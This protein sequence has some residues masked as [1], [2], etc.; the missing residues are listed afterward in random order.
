MNKMQSSGIIFLNVANNINKILS[1]YR[2][3]ICG[4]VQY[5]TKFGHASK[6]AFPWCVRNLMRGTT[7][8][9]FNVNTVV[10]KSNA[11]ICFTT[12]PHK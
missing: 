1:I 2:C 3:F 12:E 5:M 10:S 4:I 9:V 8:T 7:E 6:I 11:G